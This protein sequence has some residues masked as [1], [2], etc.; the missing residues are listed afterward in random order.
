MAP[1]NSPSVL[2]PPLLFFLVVFCGPSLAANTS[3]VPVNVGLILDFES[4]VGKIGKSFI[5]VALEDFYGTRSHNKRL[6]LHSGSSEKDVIGATNTAIGLLKNVG[7]EAIIGPQRSG[8]AEFISKLGDRT[9][10]PIVSFSATSPS[11]SSSGNSFFIS[12]AES[13]SFQVGAIVDI[14]KA[15]GWKKVVPIY[16]NSNFGM[17]VIPFLTDAL[18]QI[19]VGVPYRTLLPPSANDSFINGELDRLASNHTRVFVVHLPPAL[20]ARLFLN[21]ETKGMMSK[22]YVWIITNSLGNL[23]G[24]MNSSV[25]ASMKGVIG[26]KTYVP[27]SKPLRDFAERWRRRLVAENP[28]M[29]TQ[30]ERNAFG[31]WAYD[32]AWALALAV[33]KANGVGEYNSDALKPKKS[34]NSFELLKRVSP[35]GRNLLEAVRKTRFRGLSG[36]FQ[37]A[38]GQLRN[39]IIQIINVVGMEDLHEIGF[40]RPGFGL[41]RT[42]S[43]EDRN[44]NPNY[45]DPAIVLNPVVWPGG[46]EEVPR[47]W[48]IPTEG[49]K[50][51]IGVP[52]KDGYKDFVGVWRDPQ[53][54]ATIVTGYSI[55]VFKAVVSKLPYSLPYELFPFE[56][57]Q[58]KMAGSY[59]DLVYQVYLQRYDAVVGDTTIIA[60]RSKYVDFTLPYT[61]SGVSMIVPVK[62][63]KK[64]AWVF[65]R[66]MTLQLWLATFASFLFTGVVVWALE[67]WKGGSEFQGPPTEQ[68]GLVFYFIF[69]TMVFAHNQRLAGNLSRL[70]IVVWV[71]VVLIL[72]TSYTASLTSMLTVQQLQ[73]SVTDIQTLIRNG[74][75]IGYRNSSFVGQLLRRL[76]VPASKIRP[77]T[78]PEDFLEAFS[79]GS[80]HG[81][82]AAIFDE[83]PYNRMF[84]GQHGDEYTTVGPTYK[85]GG[86]AFAFPRGSPL[87]SDM[88]RAILNVTEGD[89]MIAIEKKWISNQTTDGVDSTSDTS[90]GSLSLSNFWGLFLITGIASTGA[91]LF[92]VLSVLLEYYKKDEG[93]SSPE[94]DTE[95]KRLWLTVLD[96]IRHF[97][98]KDLNS[99]TFR[100]MIRN[101]E[102]LEISDNAIDDRSCRQSPVSTEAGPAPHHDDDS[103]STEQ[104][105][106]TRGRSSPNHE[107]VREN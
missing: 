94:H 78:K 42:L 31:I 23:I 27:S 69:S 92:Y 105:A 47:G 21:A 99:L 84:L 45:S 2:Q 26:V 89:E 33:E 65:L 86:L 75:Y 6:I 40:W 103:T 51:R 57:D 107:I 3:A 41:S 25:I 22:D 55:D 15:Y 104:D 106:S 101:N 39:R 1:R 11:L 97:D 49:K 16:E 68:V 87:V 76:G 46:T 4:L 13:D 24:V 32:T 48:M 67:R 8:D 64:N 98:E 34:A 95:Q 28:E 102:D 66:P 53:T 60:N 59:D 43:S 81:G 74:D 50:L 38:D 36:E 91:L 96:I 90:S 14:V 82:V 30:P 80:R 29:G 18:Q 10:V 12:T 54:N 100:H 79:K 73:P 77:Y 17:G 70:V 7:V 56:N 52:V 19:G 5:S 9:H 88:S 61:E 35:A 83:I 62:P 72:T 58:G 63:H 93:P 20:G 85:T 71:F 37:L 44:R